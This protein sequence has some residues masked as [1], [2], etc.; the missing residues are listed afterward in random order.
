M[1]RLMRAAAASAAAASSPGRGVKFKH[2]VGSILAVPTRCR[3]GAGRADGLSGEQATTASPPP[4]HTPFMCQYHISFGCFC[5]VV[6]AAG[7]AQHI[8]LQ[9]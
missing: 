4:S 8:T 5:H 9:L 1:S 3:S 7:E 2:W 6:H